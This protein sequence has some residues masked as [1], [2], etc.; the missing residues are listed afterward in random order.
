M[1]PA[2]SLMMLFLICLIVY[3]IL[4]S[5]IFTGPDVIVES[6]KDYKE[7]TYTIVDEQNRELKIITY[8]KELNIGI[9]RLYSNSYLPFD[10]QIDLFSAILDRVLQ[11]KDRSE[12]H[13]LFIGRLINAFG[14]KNTQMCERLALASFNSSF[15]D[16]EAGKLLNGDLIN[17]IIEIANNEMI[18][19]ELYDMFL[20]H[21]LNLKLSR[22]EKVLISKPELMP[23]RDK[24][25][26]HGLKDDD[27]LPYDFLAWFKVTSD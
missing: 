15:W 1:K 27:K 7:V 11:D 24:L 8:E 16:R 2:K 10:K 26:R 12:F 25:K 5:F 18:F 23:F 6:N 21:D 4:T 22:V 14:D 9:I 19:R 20:E 17:F 3:I 13:T